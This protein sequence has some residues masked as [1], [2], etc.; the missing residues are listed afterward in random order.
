[1]KM[2]RE[3]F[4][5]RWESD[6]EGGGI[7]VDDCADCYVAWGLGSYPKTKRV[8]DVIAIVVRAAGCDLEGDE[9]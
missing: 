3:E 8:Q 7:T 2:T 6:D 9:P 5:K 1:M 4:K